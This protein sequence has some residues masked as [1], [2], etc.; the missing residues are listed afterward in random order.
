VGK[1][2][3]LIYGMSLPKGSSIT[4]IQ[5]VGKGFYLIEFE[6]AKTNKKLIIMNPH[7]LKSVRAFFSPWK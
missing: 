4:D 6:K 5:L 2:K 3:G 1:R 7:V